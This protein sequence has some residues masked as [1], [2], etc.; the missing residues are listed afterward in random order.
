MWRTPSAIGILALL[1]SLTSGCEPSCMKTCK[2]LV[3][4]EEVDTPRL[5][6]QECSESCETQQQVYDGWE[7]LQKREAFAELKRCVREEECGA[8]ANGV[9]YDEEL[10]IW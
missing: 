6:A 4:C 7:D 2:K 10:Y 3:E 8:I 5:S 1:S 9:C